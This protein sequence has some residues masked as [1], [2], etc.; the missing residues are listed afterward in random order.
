LLTG[1]KNAR[2]GKNKITNTVGP[3]GEDSLY[4]NSEKLIDLC[5]NSLSTKKS[6]NSFG[7]LEDTNHLLFYDKYKII[8]NNTRHQSLFNCICTQNKINAI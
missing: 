8:K 4:D 3:N 6:I 5:T 1:D 2:V 7:K